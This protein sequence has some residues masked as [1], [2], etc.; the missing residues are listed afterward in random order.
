MSLEQAVRRLT[1]ESASTFGICDR[2]LLRPGLAAD[3][4]IFDP[5]TINPLPEDDESGN[6]ALPSIHLHPDDV[7]TSRIIYCHDKMVRNFA[8]DITKFFNEKRI[9][10]VF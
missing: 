9:N 3:I 1:F 8:V 2:G 4:T 5:D 10:G 7:E 6:P